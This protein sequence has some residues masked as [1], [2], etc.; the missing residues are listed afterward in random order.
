[1]T[2][3]A[4]QGRQIR[5]SGIIL[6]VLI[7]VCVAWAWTKGRQK[8]KLPVAGKHWGWIIVIVVVFLAIVYGASGHVSQH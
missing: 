7:G 3:R 4:R 5:V 6:A 8:L 2:P 1:M